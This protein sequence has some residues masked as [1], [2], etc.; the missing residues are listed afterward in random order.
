MY[1]D[2]A[3]TTEL[4][5]QGMLGKFSNTLSFCPAHA[6]AT[7]HQT[8]HDEHHRDPHVTSANSLLRNAWSLGHLAQNTPSP[9]PSA[10]LTDTVQAPGTGRET[11]PLICSVSSTR[12]TKDGWFPSHHGIAEGRRF[13][14]QRSFEPCEKSPCSLVRE[15]TN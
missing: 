11:P 4:P 13:G 6:S 15:E 2:D 9:S 14:A 1:Q 8:T 3:L 10:V 5:V 7:S 12:R